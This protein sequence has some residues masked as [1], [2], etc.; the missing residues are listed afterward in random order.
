MPLLPGLSL[1]PLGLLLSLLE[2]PSLLLG[3][4]P[5]QLELPPPKLPQ[6]PLLQRLLSAVQASQYLSPSGTC[7]RGDGGWEAGRVPAALAQVAHNH[8]ATRAAVLTGAAFASQRRACS[9][10][11]ELRLFGADHQ[12]P[13]VARS[14]ERHSQVDKR[15][16]Q[17]LLSFNCQP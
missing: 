15:H 14:G 8:A 9:D 17:L 10:E 12:P 11:L 6:P 2:L 4:P 3:L 1:P 7:A 5:R 16:V 13:A